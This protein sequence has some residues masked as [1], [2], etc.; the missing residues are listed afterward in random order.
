MI[1]LIINLNIILIILVS[2]K[3]N[4]NSFWSYFGVTSSS[5]Q[6]GSWAAKG[7]FGNLIWSVLN[8]TDECTALV[9]S[10]GILLYIVR[11]PPII[12]I[13]FKKKKTR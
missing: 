7:E 13:I 5:I 3:L 9:G 10:M 8:R 6:F 1:K 11:Q 2:N 4:R 12:I